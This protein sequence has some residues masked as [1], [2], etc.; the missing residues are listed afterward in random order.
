[1]FLVDMSNMLYVIP[2]FPYLLFD[3]VLLT[4]G[5]VKK[6]IYLSVCLSIYLSIH[7]S[8]CLSIYKFTY[9]YIFTTYINIYIYI[10]TYIYILHIYIY[11]YIYIYIRIYIL[12]TP[13]I[14][15]KTCH[16]CIS[17]VRRSWLHLFWIMYSEA[18]SSILFH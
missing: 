17:Y 13:S 14:S 8:I 10:Y 2:K 6:K 3:R 18:A 16:L 4:H 15:T 7:L 9:T 1:M 5:G 12:I 11:V